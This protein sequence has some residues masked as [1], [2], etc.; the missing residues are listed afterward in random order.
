MSVHQCQIKTTDCMSRY[1]DEWGSIM[2]VA[3]GHFNQ[4]PCFIVMFTSGRLDYF[5][6]YDE[7]EKYL[8][9]AIPI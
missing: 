1:C 2:G 6:I 7:N 3:Y 5:P 9:R 8:F 4:T